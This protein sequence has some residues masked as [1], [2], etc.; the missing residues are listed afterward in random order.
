MVMPLTFVK[1]P[2]LV[3]LR[4]NA[5]TE[6]KSVF[7]VKIKSRFV[8]LIIGPISY[9][10]QL[11]EIGRAISTCLADDVRCYSHFNFEKLIF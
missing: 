3:F 6:L 10:N 1:D 5:A 7:E 11:Y 8:V 2:K 9:S 4:L